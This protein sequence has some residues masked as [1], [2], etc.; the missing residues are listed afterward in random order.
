MKIEIKIKPKEEY[1]EDNL[2]WSKPVPFEDFVTDPL[3]IAFEWEDG[4]TL[5]YNDFV[6]FASEYYYGLFIN[7][8]IES[9]FKEYLEDIK[10]KAWKYD[11]CCK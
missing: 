3:G 7:D 11:E 4:I 9:K 8:M 1:N 5:P 6:F 2:G 10:E